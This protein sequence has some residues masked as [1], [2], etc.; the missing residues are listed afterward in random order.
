VIDRDKLR[1]LYET[2]KKNNDKFRSDLQQG[3]KDADDARVRREV[4]S[5]L[6]ELPERLEQAATK[7][8]AEI[9]LCERGHSEWKPHRLIYS[10]VLDALKAQDIPYR[11]DW[12]CTALFCRCRRLF[13]RVV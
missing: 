8:Q 6:Y 12:G 2:G 9:F 11:I 3:W 5:I 1:S 10:R 13:A 7:G 4:E